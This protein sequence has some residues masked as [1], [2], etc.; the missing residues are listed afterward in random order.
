MS[1]RL[2][3]FSGNLM[4]PNSF[5]IAGGREGTNVFF[6]AIPIYTARGQGL[7]KKKK[8]KNNPHTGKTVLFSRSILSIPVISASY[9]IINTFVP[10]P[11]INTNFSKSTDQVDVPDKPRLNWSFAVTLAQLPLIP[12]L[13]SARGG[14]RLRFPILFPPVTSPRLSHQP[15]RETST[16]FLA[17]AG[18]FIEL[19][20]HMTALGSQ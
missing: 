10:V 17:L 5:T 15:K 16:I 8:P 18:E 1:F 3:N 4:F 9:S 12:S 19:R 2:T 14:T 7:A 20:T 11:G 13:R 6:K